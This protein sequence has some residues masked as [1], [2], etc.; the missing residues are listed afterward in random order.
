[1][2]RAYCLRVPS[3][4]QSCP[5]PHAYTQQQQTLRSSKSLTSPS[6]QR[7]TPW[8]RREM[9]DCKILPPKLMSS[10]FLS[11]HHFIPLTLLSPP[12]ST[13]LLVSLNKRMYKHTL[14]SK[15]MRNFP[16]PQVLLSDSVFIKTHSAEVQQL[17]GKITLWL[18]LRSHH[19]VLEEGGG[20]GVGAVPASLPPS[21]NF[22]RK[23]QRRAHSDVTAA[24]HRSS[25]SERHSYYNGGV[26]GLKSTTRQEP[27]GSKVCG[28]MNKDGSTWCLSVA[29][30][31]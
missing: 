17:C 2:Q 6:G 5:F 28:Q 13:R 4:L 11:A 16:S 21:F 20:G 15:L 1:M 14:P 19:R 23:V 3:P 26:Q 10:D 30:K 9:H 29:E 7:G 18:S 27:N 8:G 24:L 12:H 22:Q 25:R 31:E